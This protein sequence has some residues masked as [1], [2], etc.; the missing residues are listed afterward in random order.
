MT[1]SSPDE[2]WTPNGFR[3]LE[4]ETGQLRLHA[5]RG[6][7][8]PTLV[9]LA[10]WPETWLAWRLVLEPLARSFDVIALELRG[11]GRSGI[12]DG[13]Y[14]SAAAA[15]DVVE[16]LDR[17]G[18]ERTFLI[19]HD[20][21]AWVAF[22]LILRHPTRLAAA[23]LLDAAIPGLVEPEFFAPVNAKKVWQFYFHAQPEFAAEL[24]AGRESAYLS[25]YFEHK[26]FAPGTIP[27]ELVAA[28]VAAYSR[29]RAMWAGFRW[30]ADLAGTVAATTP[31]PSAPIA[32]PI[33]ALGG[34][35]A[36]GGLLGTSLAPF[37]SDLESGV[38]EGCGHYIPEE[39][40][41]AVLAWVGRRFLAPATRVEP[42]AW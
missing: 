18:I 10:G 39:K 27:P 25:W 38:V 26:C 5:V 23:G 19:G 1:T 4:I 6:G 29:P 42:S 14:D 22:T 21:G 9:L 17:L 36:T 8:G 15:A 37:C 35:T 12:V 33:F 24:V 32:L 31:D 20:V 13:P 40:P 16:A 3:H 28:Y 34:E 30:Y 41:E 7:E 2:A 11:Q